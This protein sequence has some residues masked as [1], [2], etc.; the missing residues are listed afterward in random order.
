M[1]LDFGA[2]DAD[3]RPLNKRLEFGNMVLSRWPIAAARNI[4][5]PRTRR[6]ARG[7]LQ[8]AA[9][10]ALVLAPGGALRVYSTHLDHVNQEERI[11]QIGFLKAR[12]NGYAMEG[13]TISGAAEY[14]FPEPPCPEAYVLMGDFNMVTGSPEH[15]AMT[16]AI[17]A[18]E[19]RQHVAHHPVDAFELAGGM[20]DGMVS[21]TDDA[22][23]ATGRLIDYAFVHAAMTARVK[24]IWIDAAARGSDHLPLWVEM[25]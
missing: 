24:R 13:G 3:G 25:D 15:A 12:I 6:Y 22:D 17:D 2:C 21:W 11:A 23:P 19:G 1:D 14:G 20:A 16:G 7:N 9:L 5:L 18:V 4:L 10:E 8:R